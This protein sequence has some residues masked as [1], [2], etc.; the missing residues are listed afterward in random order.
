MTSSEISTNPKASETTAL[1]CGKKKVELAL[2]QATTAQRG[3]IVI[4]LLF[5]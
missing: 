5:R 3:R 4:A 2:E 1:H